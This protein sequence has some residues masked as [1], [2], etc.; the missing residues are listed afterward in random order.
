M[1]IGVRLIQDW[2]QATIPSYYLGICLCLYSDPVIG[3]ISVMNRYSDGLKSFIYVMLCCEPVIYFVLVH[4]NYRL[5][6]S[7]GRNGR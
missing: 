4:L 5:C 2:K 7:T 3:W 6:K 1:Q